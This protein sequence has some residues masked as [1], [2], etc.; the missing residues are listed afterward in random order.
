MEFEN[1]KID[2]LAS[3]VEEFIEK[4]QVSSSGQSNE[5]LNRLE[6]KV[7]VIAQTGGVDYIELALSDLKQEIED[8]Q[9]ILEE[10]VGSLEDIVKKIINIST[11]IEGEKNFN[12]FNELNSTISALKDEFYSSQYNINKIYEKLDS[13]AETDLKGLKDLLSNYDEK[14]DDINSKFDE[15]KLHI[16]DRV[17]NQEKTENDEYIKNT[18]GKLEL[19]TTEIKNV[20]QN[21]QNEKITK[22]NGGVQCITQKFD[23][24]FE[25]LKAVPSEDGIEEIK[26][27]VEEI[28]ERLNELSSFLAEIKS[29]AITSNNYS[30]SSELKD[31]KN[32]FSYLEN[33]LNKTSESI[34]SLLDKKSSD[35]ND[36]VTN[37]V[38]SF[39][40]ELEQL[41]E[42]SVSIQNGIEN[43]QLFFEEDA[44]KSQFEEI[45]QEIKGL[46]N[47]FKESLELF[48]KDLSIDTFNQKLVALTGLMKDLNN[49]TFDNV[50]A[51]N[52]KLSTLVDNKTIEEFK[53]N[54]QGS[55]AEI[56]GC[57][58]EIREKI[59]Q[60]N[61]DDKFSEVKLLIEEVSVKE[62][63][64]EVVSKLEDLKDRFQ[65]DE[66]D[67]TLSDIKNQIQ[68]NSVKEEVQ[69]ILDKIQSIDSINENISNLAKNQTIEDLQNNLNDK[70]FEIIDK[71]EN[72]KGKVENLDSINESIPNLAK[73]EAI[74]DVQNKNSEIIVRLADLKSKVDNIDSINENI[75]NL[76]KNEAIEDVQN[77]NSEI[78]VRLADFK[79][80]VDNIDSIN[81]N[82]SGLAKSEIFEDLQNTLQDK[83]SEIIGQLAELKDKV[84]NIDSIN[85]NI[86]NLVK[87]ETIEDLQDNLQDKNSE[88][89]GRLED[90]KSKVDNLDFINDNISNLAKNET[91]EDIQ[92]KN[93]EIISQLEDI[94]N[95]IQDKNSEMIGRLEDINNTVSQKDLDKKLSEI[96]SK[97]DEF[98]VNDDTG[99][100]GDILNRINE[101]ISF[102]EE[103]DSKITDLQQKAEKFAVKDDISNISDKLQEVK[104]QISALE[105]DEQIDE[106]KEKFCFDETLTYIKNKT[107]ELYIRDEVIEIIGRL[108]GLNDRLAV[109]ET[110]EKLNDIENKVEAISIKDELADILK[111]ITEIKEKPPVDNAVTKKLDKLNSKLKD[112]IESK[113]QSDELDKLYPFD[114][115]T[116]LTLLD[117]K[118]EEV[119][120]HQEHAS[121][122]SVDISPQ[123]EEIKSQILALETEEKFEDLSFKIEDVKNNLRALES[124][125]HTGQNNNTDN[126]EDIQELSER[127]EYIKDKLQEN[128]IKDEIFNILNDISIIKNS[129]GAIDHNPE[130]P[131]LDAKISI[132]YEELNEL[133]AFIEDFSKTDFSA[134]SKSA[135]T[136]YKDMLPSVVD[137]AEK[138]FDR[139][140]NIV[141][142]SKRI[143]E[144]FGES[145]DNS[146][147][148]ATDTNDRVDSLLRSISEVNNTNSELSALIN[149]N[150]IE[151]NQL[152]DSINNNNKEINQLHK[153]I[154]NNNN[155]IDQLHESISNNNIQIKQLSTTINNNIDKINQLYET[156]NSN[157]NYSSIINKQ[158]EIKNQIKLNSEELIKLSD[159]L[160]ETSTSNVSLTPSPS[161]IMDLRNDITNIFGRFNE[162]KT[163][164]SDLSSR[165]NNFI[166]NTSGDNEFIKSSLNECRQLIEAPAKD[167][168]DRLNKLNNNIDSSNEGLKQI[169]FSVQDSRKHIIKSL[170]DL[171]TLINKLNYT[172]SNNQNSY[173][174]VKNILV[175][176]AEWIDSAGSLVEI[177]KEDVKD[178]KD[179]K[180]KKLFVEF[181]LIKEEMQAVEQ[182]HSK[183]IEKLLTASNQ[184][185]EELQSIIV[186][187]KNE[188]NNALEK[189]D[190]HFVKVSK[191]IEKLEGN[192]G[193][194]LAQS[195]KEHKDLKGL[196]VDILS[197]LKEVARDLSLSR[198]DISTN[199][200]RIEATLERSGGANSIIKAE[201][202]ALLTGLEQNNINNFQKLDTELTSVAQQMSNVNQSISAYEARLR[203]ELRKLNQNFMENSTVKDSGYEYSGDVSNFED[204]LNYLIE[205]SFKQMRN[206]VDENLKRIYSRFSNVETRF[207]HLDKKLDIIQKS[208]DGLRS[209]EDRSILEFI[210][211]QVTA[212][213]ETGKNS[214]VII[215]RMDTL[216][217]RIL[218]FD[219]K[220]NKLVG[221]LDKFEDYPNEYSDAAVDTNF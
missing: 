184:K 177:I 107:D 140:I 203:E 143:T 122:P 130:S 198:E 117:K 52:N 170:K 49:Y 211:G 181:K 124:Q 199:Y 189:F 193:N 121:Q 194:A 150:N 57:L 38:E 132:I 98:S 178:I 32:N 148:V 202:N 171:F 13:T 105:I 103:S 84:N 56:M 41:K 197:K 31:L 144:E 112:L 162:L 215:K 111:G 92:N 116:F 161:S 164:L 20:C 216:E 154:S 44:I 165:T 27:G 97:V 221:V 17:L 74:E 159:L 81:K 63:L 134:K 75:S 167:L 219:L 39:Q 3:L 15:L 24:V 131:G 156:T 217:K 157:N 36:E 166:R 25:L 208:H 169:G 200:K 163:D 59:T 133:K 100:F 45:S 119:K 218:D 96:K 91:I 53:S 175:Q 118:F 94:Q 104:D 70:N 196:N 205:T 37:Q 58:E 212:M 6:A 43:I 114:T 160:E 71:L 137:E 135:N 210:A 67:N 65:I 69:S 95:C 183:D 35:F 89:I 108:E 46:E 22:L 1:N 110:K 29:L 138:A 8:K 4:Y 50:K 153:S 139:I 155:G 179:D 209:Q 48:K 30:N 187:L 146:V 192:I 214:N 79:S 195:D 33:I 182:K 82:I 149:N 47:Y 145:V 5:V 90:L 77:K 173:M 207:Q 11:E 123:V 220:L 7:D 2:R 26:L 115:E 93:S 152:N 113:T 109:E 55:N 54:I 201:L 141:L 168:N 142:E 68:E 102:I 62:D 158:E 126:S 125:S 73:N 88:I 120:N 206:V 87:N 14:F 188:L 176:L 172:V 191:R 34:N 78:I 23:V 204:K 19:I 106:L 64:G 61:L 28:E 151:I 21:S 10:K 185:N 83:N 101:N 180:L 9:N 147:K 190:S 51:I 127:L 40:R 76:A 80:K 99:N 12:D 16:E 128:S 136:N 86:P 60:E 66:I 129:L 18:L 72:I 186:S 213:S 42:S 85:E 174:T